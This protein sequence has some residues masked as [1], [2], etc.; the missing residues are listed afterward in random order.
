MIST[1]KTDWKYGGVYTFSREKGEKLIYRT[2]KKAK[3]KGYH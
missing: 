2:Q 3:K 1:K